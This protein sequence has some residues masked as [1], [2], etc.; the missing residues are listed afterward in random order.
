[1]SAPAVLGVKLLV[2]GCASVGLALAGRRELGVALFVAFVASEALGH[3]VD[4]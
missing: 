3:L 1:L 2:F 4:S